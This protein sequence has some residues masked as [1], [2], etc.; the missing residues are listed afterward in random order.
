MIKKFL[1]KNKAPE[2]D[3]YN[4][5]YNNDVEIKDEGPKVSV[6]KGSKAV[7]MIVGAIFST[8]VIYFVIFKEDNSKQKSTDVKL[9]EVPAPQKPVAGESPFA[10]EEKKDPILPKE[11][12]DLVEKPVLPEAPTLPEL[13]ADSIPKEAL[14]IA[15]PDKIESLPNLNAN[16]LDNINNL[17]N[18]NDSKEKEV[19]P[20]NKSEEEKIV[21]KYKNLDPKYSPILVFSSGGGSPATGVGLEKNIIT[22]KDKNQIGNL[23]KSGV[24]VKATIVSDRSNA[25]TQGKMLTA[26]LETA[27]SSEIPGSVRGIV[28]RDV[29]GDS[30]DEILIPKGSRLFGNY[31]SKVVRGQGRIDINWTRLIRTDGVDLAITFK[32]S[33]QFGRAGVA[34][35]IDNRYGNAIFTSF[36]TSTIAATG[37]IVAQKIMGNNAQST[38][39]SNIGQQTLVTTTNAANQAVYD[40]TSSVTDIAKKIVT[41][42][43]NTEKVIRVPQGTKITVIVTA[44]MNI[45]SLRSQK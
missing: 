7:M 15:T 29:Y 4:N 27:I 6:P 44:D 30:G 41:D 21:E 14:N 40:V 22:K 3:D 28:S 11:D 19:E 9:E 31:S 42:T 32:A 12:I 18:K 34:G 5:D 45:P 16:K 8:L 2:V 38:V 17:N 39:Q 26:V 23:E 20:K 24:Q 43:L 36:L 1:N 33:D 35:D 25:I 13:P 10:I 37:A